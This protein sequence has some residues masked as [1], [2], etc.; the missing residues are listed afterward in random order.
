MIPEVLLVAGR[1]G[2]GKSSVAFEVSAQWAREGLAHCLVDGDNLCAAYPKPASDPHGSALTEANLRAVWATYAAAGYRR[3]VYVNTV[4]VL[5]RELVTRALG[6]R[7][8][9][10]GVLL[11][12]SAAPSGTGSDPGRSARRCASTWTGAPRR[13]SCWSVQPGRG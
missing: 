12:A 6:G 1:S 8:D 2:A 4:S 11:T 5:E 13:P 9:V 3:L 10:R 7:A